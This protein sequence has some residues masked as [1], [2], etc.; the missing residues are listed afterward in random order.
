MPGTSVEV[1]ERW[2]A[3]RITTQFTVLRGFNMLFYQRDTA[4]NKDL[5]HKGSG[6]VIA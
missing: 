1:I 5:I 6:G 3:V 2:K 4:S